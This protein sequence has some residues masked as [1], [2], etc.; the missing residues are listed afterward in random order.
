MTTPVQVAN[1][2]VS[3][4]G[5]RAE[6]THMKLQKLVFFAD[7]WKL[8]LTRLPLVEE[9]PQVWR[10]G[11]VFRSLYNI[12]TGRGDSPIT[13]P[14]VVNPVTGDVPLIAPDAQNEDSRLIDWIWLRYGA[15]SEL[16]LS[17]AAHATGTPWHQMAARYDFAVPFNLEI[18]ND[19]LETY[20][21]GLAITEGAIAA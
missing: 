15:F 7:G 5:S 19:V 18:P 4:F 3:R 16:D 14:V 2:F 6:L 21:R 12:L 11:P 1:S 13:A 20:F 17:R 10:Y 9:R 8:G